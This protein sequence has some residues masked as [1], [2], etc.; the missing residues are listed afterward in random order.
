MPQSTSNN[1]DLDLPPSYPGSETVRIWLVAG[2]L[3]YAL[4]LLCWLAIALSTRDGL[5]GADLALMSWLHSVGDPRDPIGSPG[6]EGIMRDI[7]ALGSNTLLVLA[8]LIGTTLLAL[9]QRPGAATFLFFSATGGLLANALVKS[10]FARGRPD[11]ISVTVTTDSTS[12]PSSHAML[13]AI[14]LLTIAAIAARERTNSAA[15]ALL[16][17]SALT[18]VLLIGVSRVY[19]GVHWPSDVLTGWVLGCAWVLGALKLAEAP[20]PPE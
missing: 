8:T 14:V 2:T 18:L 10:M 3:F 15:I 16:M 1:D 17:G 4:L 7:S 19:L 9:L 13:S 12:F 11:F 5:A 20:Q 6:F